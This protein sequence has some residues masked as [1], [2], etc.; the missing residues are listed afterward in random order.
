M[1]AADH[2]SRHVRVH[3]VDK[4]KDDLLLREVLSQRPEGPSRGRRRRGGTEQNVSMDFNNNNNNNK[5]SDITRETPPSGSFQ[6]AG[7]HSLTEHGRP[8]SFTIAAGFPDIHTSAS[9]SAAQA[10]FSLHKLGEDIIAPLNLDCGEST[11]NSYPQQITETG[12]STET[13]HFEVAVGEVL[14]QIVSQRLRDFLLSS[15]LSE[16]PNNR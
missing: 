11:T 2:C 16:L 14:D 7:P 4:D 12:F 13:P 1:G 15:S 10:F 8:R 9:G 5:A 3:H 6:Q